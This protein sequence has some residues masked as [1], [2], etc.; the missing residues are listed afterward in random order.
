MKATPICHPDFADLA[1]LNVW[2]KEH[3]AYEQPSHP[4]ELKNRHTLFRKKFTLPA[5]DAKKNRAVLR[6]TA[7]D[8]YIL[9]INGAYVTE[10]PAPAYPSAYY[11]NEIDVTEYLLAGGNIIAVHQYYQGLVN[12][13]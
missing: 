7:D 12:R 6:I 10:G 13:V 5:F 11:Y 1:P 2:H 3:A 9:R 4:E 8:C